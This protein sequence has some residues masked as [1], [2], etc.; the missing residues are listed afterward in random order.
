MESAFNNQCQDHLDILVARTFYS[1]GLPF[2]LAKNPYFIEMIK[3]AANN[4]L[5]SYTPLGYNK[6]RTTFLQKERGH[7]DK[8]L[9]S[10]KET[11]KEKGSSIVISK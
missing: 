6:S 4:S 7:V 11:W 5:M 10:I 8:L 9:G 2:H 1:V 3:Y